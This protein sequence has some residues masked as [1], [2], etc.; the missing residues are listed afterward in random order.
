MWQLLT[1]RVTSTSITLQKLLIKAVHKGKKE[2][3][4]SGRI[5]TMR[6][7]NPA[8]VSKLEDLT[9]KPMQLSD[10]MTSWTD[11]ILG[12]YL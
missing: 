10:D 1:T 2:K 3:K 9:I 8:C 4:D 12:M 5:F 7:I 11:S 6:N